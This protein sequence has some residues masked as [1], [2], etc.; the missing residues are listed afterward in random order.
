MGRLFLTSIREVSGGRIDPDY[1]IKS[2]L[3]TKHIGYYPFVSLKNLLIKPPQ[4]GA[5]EEAQNIENK[6][7]TRYIRITDIDEIGNLKSENKKTA[8]IIEEKYILNYNDLLFAR[9]GSVGK[10][11]IH[12]NMSKPSIFAGYLIR[13]VV[14]TEKCDPNF[15]FYYCNSKLYK[16]WVSAIE[17][18]AVQSNINAEEYKELPI[19]LP[20]LKKQ[21]EIANNIQQ[22]R[23][24]ALQLQTEAAEILQQTKQQI[25]Q[26]ILG[27]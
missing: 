12:K 8:Y 19:P 21:Q 20:P 4:Y 24:K 18:P 25:E 27:N 26:M 23:T 16:Y 17:R 22:M 1:I 6:D 9:S 13:F 7:Y 15:L 2:K 10:C 3:F 11:Y 14:D 5:N